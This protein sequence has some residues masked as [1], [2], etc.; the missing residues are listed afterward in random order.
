VQGAAKVGGPLL[1][2]VL[3]FRRKYFFAPDEFRVCFGSKA[4]VAVLKCRC[5]FT[6]ESRLRRAIRRRPF[7]ANFGSALSHSITSAARASSAGARV[8]PSAFAVFRLIRRS[9]L[10]G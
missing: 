4:E 10:V 8:R 2:A 3:V 7:R 9:N 5:R 1:F 6:P